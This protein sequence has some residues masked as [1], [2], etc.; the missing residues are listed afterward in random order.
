[1]KKKRLESGIGALLD[2][3]H[4]VEVGSNVLAR[5]GFMAGTDEQRSADLDAAIRRKDLPAI[6]F[7][8]G[9]VGAAR[10]LDRVD[11]SALRSRPRVLLG[12]SDLT[13]VFMAL[14][15]PG[16][17]YP[18][19][20]GPT[21]S[22]LGD[23]R[24]HDPASLSEALSLPSPTIHHSL[25]GCRILRPGRG[26]GLLIGGCLTLLVGLLGTRHDISWDGC[27]LFWEDLN[28]PPYRLDR[29]L[30]QLRLAGKLDRLAGMIVGRLV[31]C[32]PKPPTPGLPIPEIILDA[33][34]GTRYPV[35]MNFPC[36]HVPRKR[37]LL[38]GV[39]A[40]LDTGRR[41]LI[42]DTR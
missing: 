5:R 8:R 13:S 36:G 27:V 35:V 22:E 11:L 31:G 28:E 9:G 38:L 32:A 40:N 24:T 33:V 2:A 3:G 23:A 37:T 39:P 12:Y 6:F 15:R 34:A 20:Y 17:P 41:R 1:V 18:V 10:L 26:A 42:L 25:A 4:P 16:R 19:R 21:V 7:A 29:M 30:Q 14:Q